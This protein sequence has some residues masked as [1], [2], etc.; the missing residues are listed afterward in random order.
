MI[1]FGLE[2]TAWNLSAALVDEQGVLY[3]K[4]ATYT[5]AKGGIHPREAAQH[6]AEHMPKVVGDVIGYAREHGIKIER[7][8]DRFGGLPRALQGAA[9]Y[10]RYL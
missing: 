9:V 5:P 6:H 1:V 2:G 10:R 4:A 3:E 7:R 8:A